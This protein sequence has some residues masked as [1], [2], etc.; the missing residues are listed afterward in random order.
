MAERPGLVRSLPFLLFIG[1][2]ALDPLLRPFLPSGV[3]GQWL[4]GVRSALALAVVLAFWKHYAELRDPLPASLTDWGI[5][6]GMGVA[7]FFLW[8]NL[9]F[10]PLAF[11]NAGGFDPGPENGLDLGLV[12][13]RLAGATLVVPVMEEL[14]WRSFILRW[15]QRPKFLSLDP[16]GVGVRAL[17]I[18]SVLFATEHRLWF[19]GLLAGLAYGWLY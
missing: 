14:F 9:D 12:A 17:L 7:V 2:M 11:A 18:S 16:A 13:V 5:G 4:Y 3:D 1:I 10:K 15:L 6:I 19:A 8:I